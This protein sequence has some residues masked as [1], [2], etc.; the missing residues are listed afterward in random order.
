MSVSKE[1]RHAA[2]FSAASIMLA[3]ITFLS[4]RALHPS[5]PSVLIAVVTTTSSSTLPVSFYLFKADVIGLDF[6][7]AWRTATDAPINL[8]FYQGDQNLRFPTI[9]TETTPYG[10]A[11]YMSYFSWT[12]TDAARSINVKQIIFS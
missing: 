8:T 5:W 12:G 1:T 9:T 6:R 7:V 10:P 11:T 3:D 4:L 2:L